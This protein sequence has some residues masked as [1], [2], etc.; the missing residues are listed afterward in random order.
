MKGVCL[1]V[2][3]SSSS[4]LY[5]F[6]EHKQKYNN[7]G[8]YRMVSRSLAGGVYHDHDESDVLSVK[9]VVSR[10]YDLSQFYREPDGVPVKYFV[11]F[12]LGISVYVTNLKVPRAGHFDPLFSHRNLK[13]HGRY[14]G[15]RHFFVTGNHFVVRYGSSK[16]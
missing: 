11:S 5:P 6:A 2:S 9:S 1:T 14:S 10:L 8:G 3:S 16:L 12:L 4:R 13:E 7:I 15:E